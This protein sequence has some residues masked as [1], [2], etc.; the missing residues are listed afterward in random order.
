MKILNKKSIV[1][2]TLMAVVLSSVLSIP[3]LSNAETSS[4]LIT[5]IT[6]SFTTLQYSNGSTSSS[7]G[8]GTKGY[9][10]TIVFTF[11]TNKP[12][13]TV[14]L[15]NA[16]GIEELILGNSYVSAPG[17]YTLR[18]NVKFLDVDSTYTYKLVGISGEGEVFESEPFTITTPTRSG[19]TPRTEPSYYYTREYTCT[20]KA[21]DVS[22]ASA[23]LCGFADADYGT[24]P[25][26]VSYCYWE[27]S[28][29]DSIK[30]VNSGSIEAGA[31][32]SS[33][34]CKKVE[35]LKPDTD[36][37]FQVVGQF[38]GQPSLTRGNVVEFKTLSAPIATATPTEAPTP[39]PTA[40]PTATPTK[41]PTPTPTATPTAT[42]TPTKAPTPTP[43]ATPKATPT[44]APT[45]TV[46]PT[47]EKPKV[48]LGDVNLDGR[49][50][51][52]DFV[53]MKNVLIEID[54]SFTGDAAIAADVNKD[55]IFNAV[56][57]ALER[58][59]LLGIIDEF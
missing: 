42:P 36:Y 1:F 59:Y 28:N 23:T 47:P 48:V 50:N 53:L 15:K 4:D 37:S 31:N 13:V 3:L 26:N 8:Y 24:S 39:T 46:T 27:T 44:K 58:Q 16:K 34:F 21:A 56:D 33:F 55:G 11:T 41:A 45:P 30:T 9:S 43:T 38:A 32:K 2:L 57:F 12:G 35:G 19:E 18:T 49:I 6:S 7:G 29:P 20:L 52:I 14:A 5:G 17:T 51:I 54:S 10:T 40:T 22:S 25:Y